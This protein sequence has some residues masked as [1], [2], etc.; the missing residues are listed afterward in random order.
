MAKKYFIDFQISKYGSDWGAARNLT[1]VSNLSPDEIELAF[2]L[3]QE[4]LGVHLTDDSKD[5]CYFVNEGDWQIDASAFQKF[6]NIGIR[7]EVRH[8]DRNLYSQYADGNWGVTTEG[9][10]KMV[11]LII[12]YVRPDFKYKK[13][14]KEATTVYVGGY[15][16]L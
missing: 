4:M 5:F 12:K 10:M 13:I 3:G 8:N 1:L 7:P 14:S 9:Y 2:K 6:I 16:T 11:L 15:G